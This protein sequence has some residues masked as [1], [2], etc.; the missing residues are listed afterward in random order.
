MRSFIATLSI[1]FF[2]LP[3]CG[4]F[5]G[6]APPDDA[7]TPVEENNPLIPTSSGILGTNPRT[8]GVYN[9][10]TIDTIS[11]LTIE[12]VPGGLLIRATGRSE[13]RAPYNARLTPANP[14]EV[15]E[16]GVLTYQLQA[17]YVPA[18]GGSARA[19]EVIVARTL[20]DQ[21][22]GNT[23]TI[24]VEALQNSLQRRR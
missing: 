10:T 21:E 24:R 11:D 19:R 9:G 1:V 3:G 12:R 20:T 6:D 15:P 18:S 23:R 8:S 4:W 7:T 17:E 5:G 22:L 2:S 13:T 16:D 14:D